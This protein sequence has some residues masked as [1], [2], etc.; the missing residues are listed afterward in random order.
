MRVCV[1]VYADLIIL[2]RLFMCHPVVLKKFHL[3]LAS[4]ECPRNNDSDKGRR[5]EDLARER[6]SNPL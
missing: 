2:I 4:V 6:K 1:C 3:Q 5:K